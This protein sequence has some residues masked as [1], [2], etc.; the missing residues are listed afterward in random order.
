MHLR[1]WITALCLLPVVIYAIGFSPPY[2]FYSLVCFVMLLGLREFYHIIKHIPLLFEL[3]GYIISLLIAGI[4][5]KGSMYLFPFAISCCILI[6]MIISI[7]RN[8]SPQESLFQDMAKLLFGILY[9]A[10][11]LCMLMI[12]YKHPYGRAWIFFLLSLVMMGDTGAFYFGRYLGRHSLHKKISPNKTWEGAI[13]GLISSVVSGFVF[14]RIFRLVSM[15]TEILFF[16]ICLSIMGQVGDLAESFIKRSYKVKDSG[17]ILP[18]HGGILD[19]IDSFL[20]TIPIL[21]AYM[22]W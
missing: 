1:R 8:Y 9:I 20:F 17:I 19:R 10:L 14:I 16:M 3:A 21:Y 11:P 7:T 5:L 6:P 18:G 13:G 12:I 15:S 4:I 22:M 2:V